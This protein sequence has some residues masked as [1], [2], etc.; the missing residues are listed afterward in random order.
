MVV[1]AISCIRVKRKPQT[2]L[3][4]SGGNCVSECRGIARRKSRIVAQRG[5]GVKW[6]SLAKPNFPIIFGSNPCVS[7]R[8]EGNLVDSNECI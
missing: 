2:I 6:D 3:R 7:M 4:E 8:C 5:R 1:I